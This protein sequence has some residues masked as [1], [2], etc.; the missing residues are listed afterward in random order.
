MSEYILEQLFS[1]TPKP[2]EHPCITDDVSKLPKSVS[3]HAEGC[4]PQTRAVLHPSAPS[5]ERYE[6][7]HSV[8]YDLDA[9]RLNI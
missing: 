7:L 5:Q 4:L 9:E 3:R 8:L 6:K 2:E 1:L